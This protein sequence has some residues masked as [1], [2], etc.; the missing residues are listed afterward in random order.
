MNITSKLHLLKALQK[1][2]RYDGRKKEEFRDVEVEFGASHCAEGSARVKIGKTEVIAGVK[3]AI[4]TPYPDTPDKGNLM[5]NAE[6]LPASNPAFEPGPPG[7]KAIEISRVIDRGIRESKAV[8]FEKLCI[9]KGEKVWSVMIDICTINDDGDLLDVSALAAMAALIDT[10]FPEVVDDV[11]D[12]NK[13][14]DKK[15]PLVRLP[16]TVTVYKIGDNMIVD[17]IPDEEQVY[18]SRLSVAL[19]EK[20]EISAMQKGGDEPLSMDEISKMIDIVQKLAP[21]LRK[22]LKR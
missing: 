5:V 11:V 10:R 15:L 22:K 9:E 18:D 7:D 16:V 4:E 3:M 1:N 13:K 19:T 12:Y 8:E 6:L 17:P 21:E 14:T 20:D 2:T